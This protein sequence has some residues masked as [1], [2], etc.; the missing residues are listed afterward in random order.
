[1]NT[2]ASAPGVLRFG[3]LLRWE[4]TGDG[5]AAWCRGRRH[6]IVKISR[7]YANALGGG[8]RPGWHFAAH[9]DAPAGSPGLGPRLGGRLDTA[10]TLAEVWIL[11]D[12]RDRQ[13][14]GDAPNLVT[15]MSGGG[16]VFRAVSGRLLAAWP[17]L[18]TGAIHVRTEPGAD[19][20]GT[21]TARY[22]L[23]AGV[24]W[25]VTDLEGREW[26][27]SDRWHDAC[28]AIGGDR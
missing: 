15:A 11:T 7:G 14:A 28:R 8:C 22:A 21:I 19:L 2:I 26:A 6:E 3:D 24:S 9:P 17:D 20:V 4:R 16:A 13:P 23:S 12:E 10:R 25:H 1:M 5:H 18:D 27:A